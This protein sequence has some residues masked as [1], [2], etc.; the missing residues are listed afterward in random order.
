MTPTQTLRKLGVIR[1]YR[2]DK[3]CLRRRNGAEQVAIFR[4]HYEHFPFHRALRRS[5]THGF[6]CDKTQI[7]QVLVRPEFTKTVACEGGSVGRRPCAWVVRLSVAE[8]LA[9]NI[10]FLRPVHAGRWGYLVVGVWLLFVAL[11]AGGVG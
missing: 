7:L 5:T 3:P 4:I 1:G 8:A 11:P 10:P 9:T 2:G 6:P